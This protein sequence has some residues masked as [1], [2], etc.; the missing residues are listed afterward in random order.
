MYNF[1]MLH[2]TIP[3]SENFGSQSNNSAFHAIGKSHV[4]TFLM[5]REN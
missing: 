4:L 2:L 1:F 3:M 5:S